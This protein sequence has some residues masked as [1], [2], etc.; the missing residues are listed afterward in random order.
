MYAHMGQ[1]VCKTELRDGMLLSVSD[2]SSRGL[3][4]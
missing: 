4:T 3:E 2:I 1:V